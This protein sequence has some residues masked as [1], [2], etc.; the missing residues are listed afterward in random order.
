MY[1]AHHRNKLVLFHIWI[2]YSASKP[3]FMN[4]FNLD[5]RVMLFVRRKNLIWHSKLSYMF[6]LILNKN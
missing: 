6:S 3:I 4:K 5:L 2:R 1:F